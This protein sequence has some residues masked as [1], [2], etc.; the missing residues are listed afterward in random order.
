MPEPHAHV[1]G[2]TEYRWGNGLRAVLFP[3]PGQATFTLNATIFVGSRHEGHTQSG[4]AHLLEHLLFKGTERHPDIPAALQRRG[5]QFNG[6]TWLD[7]TNYYETLPATPE[8]LEFAIRLEADR[9]LE[10]RLTAEDLASEL[11]VIA[12]E[13]RRNDNSPSRVL[14]QRMLASAYHWHNYGR[15]TIGNIDDLQR[16]SL[17][18]LKRFYRH[19]YRPSNLLLVLSGSFSTS[20]AL[21]LIEEQFGGLSNPPEP[22][23][24]LATSEP[25][26]DG[27]RTV[28]V[29]R[30]G[31]VQHVA[32]MYK[33]P[34]GNHPEY[35]AVELLTTI[36]SDEPGGALYRQL[37]QTQLASTVFGGSL[38]L[39]EPGVALFGAQLAPSQDLA[40]AEERLLEVI[41]SSGPAAVDEQQLERSKLQFRKSRQLRAGNTSAIAIELSE[42]AAQGD[43]RLYF[44]HRDRIEQ[45]TVEQ[46]REAAGRY[47][48]RN[49]RTL[50]RFCP[51]TGSP[52]ASLPPTY[53]LQP[54]LAGYQG[55]PAIGSGETLDPAPLAIGR[56][57]IFRRLEC[58]LQVCLLPKRTRGG[59]V[60]LLLQ[61]RYGTAESLAGRR[62]TCQMLGSMLLRGTERLDHQQLSDRW[63]QLLAAVRIQSQP[64]IMQL[65]V[66]T[67][68]DRL[69]DVLALMEEMLRSPSLDPSQLE[70]IKQQDRSAIE[71]RRHDPQALA[72]LAVARALNPY[73]SHDVRYRPSLQQQLEELEALQADQLVELHRRWLGPQAG[74]LAVVGDFDPSTLEGDL[75]GWFSG[76]TA[77]EPF[78]RL[79]WEANTQLE[80]RQLLIETPDKPNATL[81]ASHQIAMTEQHE[82]FPAC[83]LAN[84][85][86]GGNSLSSRLG[87]RIRQQA[88]LSYSI[89]SGF[90]A[91]PLDPWASWSLMA[92]ASPEHRQQLWSLMLEELQRLLEAGVA[93]DELA[94]AKE[95]YL[96]AQRM[97]RCRDAYLAHLLMTNLTV[98]RGVDFQHRLE[99]GIEQLDPAALQRKLQIW[100]N[101][102]RLVVAM[103]GA[104]GAT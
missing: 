37:V 84:Y 50:G 3:D 45:V 56:R 104:F 8:N 30:T 68:R 53:D 70:L 96:Q 41:E 85:I 49:N 24:P 59:I 72:P 16:V 36:L 43:W 98:G 12:S 9:L 1:E 73:P 100:L 14:Q 46:L 102:S 78:E 31:D 28:V 88:G 87:E 79:R 20:T 66:Q 64:G 5:A 39:F 22:L 23:E 97:K 76:W 29:R 94:A 47:L 33:I 48:Q 69:A 13:S 7:R 32:C 38:A 77:A 67:Q 17:V 2:I 81:Y 90:S 101:P 80:G 55:E 92:I 4:W 52:K 82:D 35:A 11:S 6:T 19:H 61:L 58:G 21:Q 83:V 71:A 54:L 103:A 86:L 74:Q 99:Q 51:T 95:G 62:A 75:G 27:E 42:W 93:P 60:H 40:A 65:H 57:L 34:P 89:A 91:H 26:Q 63:D 10:S 44:L 15:S 25:P 18:E